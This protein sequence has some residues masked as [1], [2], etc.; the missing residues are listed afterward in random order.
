MKF[1]ARTATAVIMANMIGTGV[2]TSLGFQLADIR[3]E[4]VLLMLWV[5][6]GLTALCGALTYAE[7]GAALPRSGGEYNFLGRIYHPGVGFVSGWISATI[8]FA[9]PTALAAITF[10][11]YLASVFPAL[12]PAWLACGLVGVL[13][14][15]HATSRRSSGRVQRAFTAVKILLI[16]GFCLLAA[17]LVDEPQAIS[18]L[19]R[20]G[21][22]TLLTSGAFAVA[23]IYVNYA[24]TGWNAATYLTGEL[25][26]PEQT[27]SR[28]LLQGTVV[29][30][31]LYLLLNVTFLYVAP[32]QDMMGR[33]EIG[34]VAAEHAFGPNGAAIM[35]VILALLLISTASA[36][37]MAGP[38][39]LQVIGE[40]HQAFKVLA[41]VN[42]DGVPAVAVMV[43]AGLTLLF[44]LT[45]SFESILVF[46][47]FTLGVSTFFTVLGIFVL[48]R[49][50]P[51]LPRPYRVWGYPLPPLIFLAITGWTLTYILAQRPVEGLWG[52]G[53]IASGAILYAFTR[54]RRPPGSASA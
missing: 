26:R 15:A 44:I 10:G 46:A 35:A 31:L 28:V 40:D 12:S 29:V 4:F 9:A 17:L 52:L 20:A 48:R 50:S 53:I 36:M 39:V 33:L 27:L 22:G 14:F 41:K 47:G 38:R 13:T 5:V 51:N 37:I 21:D 45:A 25:D 2:F 30:M 7:L 23:L 18:L 42:A 6:G 24:Y 19:P 16:L 43:Q 8:G 3:S 11:T 1:S 34:Y 54:P 49:R 32:A